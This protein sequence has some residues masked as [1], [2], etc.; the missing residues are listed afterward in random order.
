MCLTNILTVHIKPN[1]QVFFNWNRLYSY[2]LIN[3]FILI[4]GRGIGKTTGALIDCV[5][6]Y[7]KTREQFVYVRRY[8]SEL[9]KCKGLLSKI[10]K[11]Y[12]IRG[13]GDG[14]IEYVD[15]EGGIIGW[16]IALTVQQT[17]KSGIN[18]ENVTRIIYDEVT[19]ARGGVL[20]YINN[21]IDQFLEL[22]S[23]IVRERSN[24]KVYFIGNNND[25][26]N[27]YIEYFNINIKQNPYVDYERGIYF[28]YCKTKEALIEIEKETPLYRVT[29]G[30]AY[31]Q[32]H[33]ANEVLVADNN[34]LGVKDA[35]ATFLTRLLFNDVTL[36]VY[37]QDNGSAFIEYRDK[38]IEDSYTYV[39]MKKSEYN[40]YY[41]RLFKDSSIGRYLIRA[42]FTEDVWYQN[43]KCASIIQDFMQY[44]G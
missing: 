21:E 1:Y 31:H 2:K 10:T 11:D 12:R 42:F 28:E 16:A 36:N 37:M 38:P 20:R 23:S 9:K 27:P 8:K 40:L 29:K 26:F 6:A 13:G 4:G 25:L 14:V 22:L 35:H 34:K 32:Y 7:N 30:T 15:K 19:I 18:F 43:N 17:V 33:Y 44:V 39:I 3:F 5:K 41:C 24:Y